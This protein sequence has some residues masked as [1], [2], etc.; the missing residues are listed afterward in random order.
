MKVSSLAITFAAAAATVAVAAWLFPLAFADRLSTPARLAGVALLGLPREALPQLLS[1]ASP[2]LLERKITLELRGQ[3][4]TASLREVGVKLDIPATI[5]ALRLVFRVAPEPLAARVGVLFGSY[6]HPPRNASLRLMSARRLDLIPGQPGEVIDDQ[7]LVA[8]LAQPSAL[9][10][11]IALSVAT[12]PPRV[13]DTEVAS[14]QATAQRLMQDGLTL[15]FADRTFSLTPVQ[16]RPMLEFVEQVD[17]RGPDNFILGVRL[18]PEKLRRQLQGV[19]QQI[20]QDPIDAKFEINQNEGEVPRVSEFAPPRRGLTLDIETTAQR[21][22]ETMTRGATTTLLTVDVTE[23]SI[24]QQADLEKLGIAA[25][26]ARGETDF[27]GSPRN[28]IHNISVGARR[29]HGLLIAPGEEFSFNQYLGPVTAAAGFKPE[30]VIKEHATVPEYGGGLCQVSTTAFRAAVYA[31]LPVAERRNHAY[32]VRYYGTPG[33]DATIYP[34]YTDLR[35]ENN[36]PGHILIQTRLEGTKLIFEFWGTPDG[37]VVEV[38]GPHPYNRRPDGAVKATLTQRVA[39]EGQ[40]LFEKTF[41]S[42]YKSPN[43]FPHIL[44][45]NGESKINP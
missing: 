16:L 22:G 13:T 9:T 7:A 4:Q 39:R 17:P 2:T 42:N 28:R 45:A 19:A 3:Q 8:A 24:G 10:H 35:F 18:D 36:T 43:L 40:T 6:L 29:Y 5:R 34:G 15:T 33:F 37:R 23:P 26:V 41:Q 14:A 11:P 44:A 20:D 32:A 21:I 38:D 31:G 27:A 12:A 25:L 30:L 1:A